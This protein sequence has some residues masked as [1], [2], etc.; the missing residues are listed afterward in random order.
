MRLGKHD[1]SESPQAEEPGNMARV[2]LAEGETGWA[3]VV[4]PGL[5]RIANIPYDGI[6]NIDDVVRVDVEAMVAD[7]DQVLKGTIEKRE[8]PVRTM[9]VYP[10]V[11]DFKK[12]IA[13][14]KKLGGK[15][16]GAI[17][18]SRGRPGFISLA[19]KSEADVLKIVRDLE[20]PQE[21]EKGWLPN[22]L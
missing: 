21:T 8:F 20:L 5:V 10:K 16:E 6:Y 2:R 12:I 9:L 4:G 11:S 14:V 19:A 17:G 18:P 22:F 15:M 3:E 13:M 1:T 7:P